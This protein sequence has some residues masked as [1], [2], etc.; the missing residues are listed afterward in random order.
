MVL[1][2]YLV[3]YVTVNHGNRVRAPEA[4]KHAPIAKWTIATLNENERLQDNTVGPKRTKWIE[5]AEAPKY[6]S[7]K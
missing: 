7:G 1:L 2:A 4:P 3:K 5:F 6:L